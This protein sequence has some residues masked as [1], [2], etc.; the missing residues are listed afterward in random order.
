MLVMTVPGL[1]K[2]LQRF[3]E[4]DPRRAKVTLALNSFD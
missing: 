1:I 4:V 2:N 3:E